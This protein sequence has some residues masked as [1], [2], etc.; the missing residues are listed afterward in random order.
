VR[1]SI[2]SPGGEDPRWWCDFEEDREK[3]VVDREPWKVTFGGCV[4][5]G[6]TD[7]APLVCTGSCPD[8]EGALDLQ[9]RNITDVP[10]TAFQGMGNMTKLYL[11]F[12]RLSTRLS[13]FW[14]I[15]KKKKK[16][17]STAKACVHVIRRISWCRPY[18]QH[19]GKSSSPELITAGSVANCITGQ[20]GFFP[21]SKGLVAATDL[22]RKR[23]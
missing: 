8:A 20:R 12:N 21:A 11:E 13:F 5:T 7:G 2:F 1:D 14:K 10:V 19:E 17:K 3:T 18:M 22:G 9:Y 4:F 16:M 15:E 23:F 6:N